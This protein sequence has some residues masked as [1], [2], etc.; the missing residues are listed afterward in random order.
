[1]KTSAN[2]RGNNSETPSRSLG[3][4]PPIVSFLSPRCSRKDGPRVGG[5]TLGDSCLPSFCQHLV[6]TSSLCRAAGGPLYR[7][8]DSGTSAQ[9]WR[10]GGG[11]RWQAPF[12]VERPEPGGSP[13]EAAQCL[14]LTRDQIPEHDHGHHSISRTGNRPGSVTVDFLPSGKSL[15]PEGVTS[16][17]FRSASVRGFKR[18]KTSPNGRHRS[19]RAQLPTQAACAISHTG[20]VSANYASLSHQTHL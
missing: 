8:S 9:T 6:S 7:S 20:S 5:A 18:K 13:L 11:A 19:C 17:S 16:G 10:L 4:V 12:P 1:M 15:S 3:S 14:P 2:K